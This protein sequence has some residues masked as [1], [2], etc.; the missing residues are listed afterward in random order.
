MC[1]QIQIVFQNPY[2]SL[3]PSKTIQELF[4]Q[5]MRIHGMKNQAERVEKS[6]SCLRKLTCDRSIC[7]AMPTSYQVVS[8]RKYVLQELRA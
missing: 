8:V 4:E 5:P 3:N 1:R 7:I 6:V 2:S